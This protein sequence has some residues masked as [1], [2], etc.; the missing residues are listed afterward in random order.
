VIDI[1]TPSPGPKKKREQVMAIS[2]NN[3]HQLLVMG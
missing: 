1:G 3:I 2:I